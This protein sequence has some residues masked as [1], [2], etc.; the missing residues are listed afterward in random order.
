M[1][2]GRA[3]NG[4]M[5]IAMMMLLGLLAVGPTCARPKLEGVAD[6]KEVQAKV[7][8]VTR[9]ATPATVL[10]L[11][12]ETGGSGSGVVVSKDG[13]VLTAAHVVENAKTVSVVFPDGTESQG[14]V[15]GANYSRDAA[16]VRLPEGR[17]WPFAEPG[18]SKKLAV[19]DFVVAMGHPKGYDPTR[20]PPVRFGRVMTKG[21]L[22]FVTTDC[23]LIGGDSGGPLFD[24]EGKVVAIHSNIAPDR[25]VNNHAGIESYQRDWA[26]LE[27]GD[28]WGSL[29]A[30]QLER[31]DRPVMGVVLGAEEEGDRK[32]VV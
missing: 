23:T 6:L 4:E 19:G 17:E 21:R 26:R 1:E 14:T 13:L 8:E 28:E 24:L 3:G 32:S 20:R 7:I 18:D 12:P 16:M 11:S 31:E 10:I 5:K 15:L 9:K 22:G 27:K 25:E 29:G 30:F 2:S